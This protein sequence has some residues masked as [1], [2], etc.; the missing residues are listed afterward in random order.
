MREGMETAL[1]PPLPLLPKPPALS[2]KSFGRINTSM[3]LLLHPYLSAISP[4]LCWSV[5][6]KYGSFGSSTITSSHSSARMMMSYATKSLAVV[7]MMSAI[8]WGVRPPDPSGCTQL[9]MYT[10][11]NK[12]GAAAGLPAYTPA[13]SGSGSTPS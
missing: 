1:P 12:S 11:T 4:K 10:F 7:C 3:P 6:R 8:C 2:R 5:D 9:C 13:G